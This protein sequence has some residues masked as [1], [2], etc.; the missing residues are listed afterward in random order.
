MPNLTR[1]EAL[2]DWYAT[3]RGQAL[4]ARITL[5]MPEALSRVTGSEHVQVCE[6]FWSEIMSG[7]RVISYGDVFEESGLSFPQNSLDS[8]L[9]INTLDVAEQPQRVL[10]IADK[11]VTKSGLIT[12]VSFNPWSVLGW[13]YA[14]FRCLP[15][16]WFGHYQTGF[17]RSGKIK[18]W[19][20]VLNYD[21]REFP[22][23]PK[24]NQG[25]LN[26]VRLFFRKYGILPNVSPVTIL[27]AK[28][29][30]FPMT[31]VTSGQ[32]K[33]P[34]QPA[35]AG[36]AMPVQCDKQTRSDKNA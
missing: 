8:V 4:Q 35:L 36:V 34:F 29:P 2:S 14:V 33:R 28:K 18:D 15:K 24:S 17:H 10:H 3:P 32:K 16:K 27:V 13:K 12:V 22:L 1:C 23:S 21:V 11:L 5:A 7:A 19:L 20:H 30:W 6:G 25:V 9:L 31:G 26:K